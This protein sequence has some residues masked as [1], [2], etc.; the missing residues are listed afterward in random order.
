MN[1]ICSPAIYN[2]LDILKSSCNDSY[3]FVAPEIIG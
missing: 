1:L 3:N 2:V